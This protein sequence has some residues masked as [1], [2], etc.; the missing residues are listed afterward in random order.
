MAAAAT[1]DPDLHR[2]HLDEVFA[3]IAPCFPRRESRQGFRQLMTGMLM[4]VEDRNCW[5]LAEALGHPG[6]H[7]RQN[8]LSR[9]AWDDAEVLAATAR[10]AMDQLGYADPVLIADE[11][12]D[13]KSSTDAV[14]AA[15][16]CSGALRGVALCQVAVHLTYATAAGHA[17]VDRRLYLPEQWAADDERREL[18]HAPDEMA[19]ATSADAPDAQCGARRRHPVRLLPGR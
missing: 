4:E 6:P 11:T 9:A 14:G 12:G 18:V 5:S 19:F 10:W 17:I 1:I 2:R 15:F 3:Q 16:Q 7:R 13:A 8:L